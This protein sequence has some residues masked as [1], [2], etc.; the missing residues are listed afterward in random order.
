MT[1]MGLK[2]E[3]K[4]HFLSRKQQM[5]LETFLKI[6]TIEEKKTLFLKRCLVT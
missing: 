5:I 6:T 4:T 2:T 3:K 1:E